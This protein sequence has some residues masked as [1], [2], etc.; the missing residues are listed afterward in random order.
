[1]ALAA[2]LCTASLF[3]QTTAEEYLS[4][5]RLLAG[6]LG[7]D[8]LRI[9]TLDDKWEADYPDDVNMLI[10]KFNYY[11]AKC[12]ESKVVSKDQARYLG[13]EPILSL[14]DSTGAKVNYFTEISFDDEMYGMASQ[15]LDKAIRLHPDDISLRFSKV[16]SLISYEKESPD[17]ATQAL[18]GLIDYNASTQPAWT[19]GEN[20]F[21]Q[22]EFRASVLEYC[23]VLFR[24]ASPTSLEAFKTVSDKML[25]YAP[26]DVDFLNNIG[27]YHM[28]AKKDY[29]TALKYYA[30]SL[31]QDPANYNAIKNGVLA[32]RRSG[33]A[34]MEKKYLQLLMRHS[35]DEMERNSAKVRL[36]AMK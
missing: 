13:A 10:A 28:A 11:Y 16:T 24:I 12:Q 6:K 26:K 7:L 34:K 30:K 14:N 15:A 1:M 19:Y 23:Y 9:E 2:F 33:N 32:A 18:L 3:A 35:P 8:G 27:S 4:R 21:T 25:S 20:P 31:K 29:K 5:Y 36:E 17:M 22:E